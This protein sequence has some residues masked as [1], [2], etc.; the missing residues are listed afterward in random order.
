MRTVQCAEQ[1]RKR[2]SQLDGTVLS[3]RHRPT[4]SVW[5]FVG[6]CW[7]RFMVGSD[8]SHWDN[9]LVYRMSSKKASGRIY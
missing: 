5:Y 9:R 6:A 2:H 7:R 3:G 4:W 8:S 1:S